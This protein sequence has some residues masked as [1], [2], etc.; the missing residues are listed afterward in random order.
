MK[1]DT[2][3]TCP[4]KTAPPLASLVVVRAAAAH[5]GVIQIV[6]DLQRE[7]WRGKGAGGGENPRK[8]K[9]NNIM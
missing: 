6:A 7:E 5:C 8:R 1:T 3:L 4:S 2:K 9:F